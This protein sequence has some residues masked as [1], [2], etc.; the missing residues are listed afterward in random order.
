[1][2]T[3]KKQ[4]KKLSLIVVFGGINVPSATLFKEGAAHHSNAVQQPH[5]AAV[6]SGVIG[7]N[8]K[9]AFKSF[10]PFFR[11]EEMSLYQ[12]FLQ[13]NPLKVFFTC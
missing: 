5:V 7:Q 11:S 13:V 12:L 4:S 8:L 2:Y 10:P 9:N 3:G 6:R 1:V